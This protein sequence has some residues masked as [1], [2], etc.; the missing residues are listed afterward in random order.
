MSLESITNENKEIV[1]NIR[2]A[3][4]DDFVGFREVHYRSWLDTYVNDEIGITKED[5]GK[6]FENRFS[7]ERL[8]K[9]KVMIGQPNIYVLVAMSGDE[10]IGFA[11]FYVGSTHNKLRAIYVHPDFI[12]KK[13]GIKLWE[14]GKSFINPDLPTE[15][16]VASYNQ[17][18]IDFYQKLGFVMTDKPASPPI[19]MPISGIT[20]PVKV[21]ELKPLSS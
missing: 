3:K 5:I 1:V 9:Y 2:K 14:A 21:M 15:L 17:R 16:E 20:I 12:G 18:A 6:R 11:D 19:T 13:V 10:V 4:P 8:E 7:D